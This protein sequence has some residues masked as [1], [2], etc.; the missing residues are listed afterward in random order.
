MVFILERFRIKIMI[1]MLIILP[2]FWEII[3]TLQRSSSKV[4]FIFFK[5]IKANILQKKRINLSNGSIRVLLSVVYK[6][7][8]PPET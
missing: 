8:I 1:L 7:H 5:T 3:M 4:I 2:H 6:A